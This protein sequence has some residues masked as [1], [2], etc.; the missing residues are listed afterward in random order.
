MCSHWD[1]NFR[2]KEIRAGPSLSAR[3][4]ALLSGALLLLPVCGAASQVQ[5]SLIISPASVVFART[6][7]GSKLAPVSITVSNPASSTIVLE[8]MIVSGIDFAETTDCGKQLA[9][10]AKCS[11]QIVFQPAISGERIGNLVIAASDSNLP[12]FVPLT[13]TG[14]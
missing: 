11:I 2:R 7:V 5:N 13:G 1:R 6:P 10:G 8:E 14:E 12:H 3:I 4:I 9:P